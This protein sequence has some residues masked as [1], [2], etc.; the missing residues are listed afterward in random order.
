VND[1]VSPEEIESEAYDLPL[2]GDPAR[3]SGHLGACAECRALL[4]RFRRERSLLEGAVASAS[5]PPELGDRLA[6]TLRGLTR[7]TRPHVLARFS[8]AGVAAAVLGLFVLRLGVEVAELRAEVRR[9]RAAPAAAGTPELPPPLRKTPVAPPARFVGLQGPSV[10]RPAADA[11]GPSREDSG[12]P[13]RMLPS[14]DRLVRL[15]RD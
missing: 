14:L 10:P 12:A 2:P 15:S 5:V 8:A 11:K 7:R 6:A 3:V 13:A 9:L 1:H 4:E